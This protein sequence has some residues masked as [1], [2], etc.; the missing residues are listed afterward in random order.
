V[1]EAAPARRQLAL[2]APVYRTPPTEVFSS[3]AGA[4]RGVRRE[5]R[6]A[7]IS[8]AD[9]F[10]QTGTPRPELYWF[11]ALPVP[12]DARVYLTVVDELRAQ[13]LID[14]EV[15]TPAVSGL[16]RIV[17]ARDLEPDVSYR[18]SVSISLDA[19]NPAIDRIA[20][21]GIRYAPPSEA[22]QARIDAADAG[23]VP[24]IWA[25]AGY[26]YDAFRALEALA[27]TRQDPRAEATPVEIAE[28]ALI[29]AA[30]RTPGDLGLPDS[31]SPL[32]TR[33]RDE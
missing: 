16:Q 6:L 13:D 3:L 28:A 24:A 19:Q 31:C 23:A 27:R 33:D 5:A 1:D 2:V 14:V 17:L 32:P 4:V 22:L 8:P 11:S 21:G 10:G 7:T 26:F 9:H 20:S 30:G 15:A 29:C 25:E 18:W 12:E